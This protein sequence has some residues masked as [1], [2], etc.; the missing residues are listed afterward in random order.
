MQ[1][2]SYLGKIA[3]VSIWFTM[4]LIQI[5]TWD[6]KDS[7]TLTYLPNINIEVVLQF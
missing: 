7:L 6:Y 4:V 3:R 2:P 1:E 5:I